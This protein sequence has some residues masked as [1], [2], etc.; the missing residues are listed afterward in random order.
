[1]EMTKYT[2]P[3]GDS[4]TP[5]QFD[6][7]DS[8]SVNKMSDL[9][10]Y[11]GYTDTDIAGIEVDYEN[12]T[13]TR[14]AGAVGKNAGSDFNTFPVYGGMRR[15]NLADDGTVNAYYG[16]KGRYPAGYTGVQGAVLF[17]TQPP[18]VHMCGAYGTSCSG[19]I[20]YRA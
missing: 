6:I 20:P 1:M 14:L 5:T 7:R 15:C 3:I 11:I 17:R 4:R 2:V 9:K 16:D 12:N 8:D 13:F 18:S 10:A 19:D